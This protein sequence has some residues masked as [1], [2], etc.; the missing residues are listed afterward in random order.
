[1]R[2]YSTGHYYIDKTS[3]SVAVPV[4]R[5][6]VVIS[7]CFVIFTNV[8]HSLKPGEAPRNSA[9]HQTS[10]SVQR[11]KISQNT[12]KRCVAVALRL[13]LFLQFT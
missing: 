3:G 7:P 12:L 1:M 2:T 4:N 13:W 6:F 8:V 11:S 10:N 5:N 9:S